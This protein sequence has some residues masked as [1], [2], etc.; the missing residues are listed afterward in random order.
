MRILISDRA[1]ANQ[2]RIR[3]YEV[4]DASLLSLVEEE[5]KVMQLASQKPIRVNA[6]LDKKIF[7]D[8]TL[9]WRTMQDN[10]GHF[11]ASRWNTLIGTRMIMLGGWLEGPR[12][13]N[14]RVGL[15]IFSSMLWPM[16]DA[17]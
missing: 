7:L 12:Q 3:F 4:G 5:A 8:P 14:K 2:G 16:G 9:F 1:Y 11:K 17:S 15:S 13:M 6:R 10:Y